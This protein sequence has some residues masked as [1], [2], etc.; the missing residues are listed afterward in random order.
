MRMEHWL[1]LLIFIGRVGDI[2]ST[3]LLTP[4][5]ALEANPLVRRHKIPMFALGFLLCL[6]PYFDI[7]LGVMVAVPSLLVSA[8]NLSRAWMVRALGEEEIRSLT[9][10]AAR[11]SSLAEALA[12]VWGASAFFFLAAV[13]LWW[14]AADDLV[15]WYFANGVALYGAIFGLYATLAFVRIFERARAE[16]GNAA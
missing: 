16:G 14:L 11:R 5:M 13:P 1:A 10:R 3:H 12:L 6:V 8:S 4:T 9:A 2:W 7:P 15:A